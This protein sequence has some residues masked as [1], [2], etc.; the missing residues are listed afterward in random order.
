MGG[1]PVLSAVVDREGATLHV[2]ENELDRLVAEELGDLG[3]FEVRAVPWFAPL[4]RAACLAEAD[5]AA[6]L[7]ALRADL[8]PQE[9]ARYRTLG[10]D[11]A[12]AVTRLL[13]TLRSEHS[14]REVAALLAREIVAIGAEPAVL[15][16]AGQDRLGLRHPLPTHAPLGRR[17]MIVVGAR[18]AGLM[19]NLTRWVGDEPGA[20]ETA[21]RLHKVEADA[22]AATRPGRALSAVLADIATSYERHGFGPD[23]WRRHHQGGPTGYVGR[24]P[25]AT[26]SASDVVVDGQAFAWNPTA[27]RHKAEDTVVVSHGVVEV[28][29]VDPAWPAAPVRGILR[30]QPM[31]FD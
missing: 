4:P 1:D 6:D 31:P 16:V 18:R 24:D 23:E 20:A 3:G 13:A 15:L 30:P 10:R 26:P 21:V 25:R 14:E 29:T 19:A 22:F 5:V 12:A 9:L 11:A 2:Y 8:L 17:A 7:R 28:L 27:P